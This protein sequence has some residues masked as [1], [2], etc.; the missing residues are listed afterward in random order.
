MLN[1]RNDNQALI[2]LNNSWSCVLDVVNFLTLSPFIPNKAEKQFF[3]I[4]Y[5]YRLYFNVCN[6]LLSHTYLFISDIK[7]I[8]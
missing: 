8:L 7:P 6:M 2:K 3:T 1:C 4:K 5:K